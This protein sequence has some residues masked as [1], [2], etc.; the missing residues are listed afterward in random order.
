ME[1]VRSFVRAPGAPSA[2]DLCS[3]MAHLTGIFAP[4]GGMCHESGAGDLD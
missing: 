1:L 3:S 2:Q 4:E